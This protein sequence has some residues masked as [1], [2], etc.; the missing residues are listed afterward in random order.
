MCISD[1]PDDESDDHNERIRGQHFLSHQRYGQR[2]KGPN[3]TLVTTKQKYNRALFLML[4]VVLLQFNGG[5]STM[6]I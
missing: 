2:K 6:P 3:A 4:V 1:S 5:H